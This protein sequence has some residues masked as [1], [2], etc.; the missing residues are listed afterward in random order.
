MAHAKRP[1]TD[2]ITEELTNALAKIDGLRVTSRT[3]AFALKGQNLDV[4][5]I[6]ARLKVGT[7]LEGSV[8]REDNAL[9]VTAQLINV[10]DGYHLW[11]QSYDRELK[12]VFALEDEIAGSIAQALRRKLGGGSKPPTA[13]LAA[14][15]L[16]LKGRYFWNKRTLVG[17]QRAAEHFEQAIQRDATYALA[18]RP[19]PRRSPR[20]ARGHRRG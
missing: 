10:S 7:L 17:F 9:R 13:D 19:E 3:A 18:A 4:Q 11:S 20:R 14:H 15:D 1:A 2:G 8:R 12:S 16:Y 5:K 6:G